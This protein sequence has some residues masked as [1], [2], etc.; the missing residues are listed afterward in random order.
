[1]RLPRPLVG[2]ASLGQI[3]GNLGKAYE[4]AILGL[5]GIDDDTRPK[6][7]AVFTDAPALCF[8]FASSRG[9][10]QCLCRNLRDAL[11]SGIKR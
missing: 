1:L 9:D 4:F 3:T 6:R 8:V 11:I 2:S 5:D 10:C 7:A